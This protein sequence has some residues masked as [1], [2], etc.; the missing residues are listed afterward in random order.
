MSPYRAAR[1]SA[2]EDQDDSKTDDAISDAVD[3]I[4]VDKIEDDLI[5]HCLRKCL[6]L[7]IT[8]ADVVRLLDCKPSESQPPLW[9][10]PPIPSEPLKPSKFISA[11]EKANFRRVIQH[12]TLDAKSLRPEKDQSTSHLPGSEVAEIFGWLSIAKGVQHIIQLAKIDVEVLDWSKLDMCPE[13]IRTSCQDVRVLHL[14]WS[15]NNAVLRSWSEPEGLPRLKILEMIHLHW[16]FEMVSDTHQRVVVNIHKFIARLKALRSDVK[17]VLRP[18]ISSN[19][20][21]EIRDIDHGMGCPSVKIKFFPLLEHSSVAEIEETLVMAFEQA[22]DIVVIRRDLQTIFDKS[23]KDERNFNKVKYE[24]KD[25][26]KKDKS[27]L[28][29]CQTYDRDRLWPVEFGSIIRV[30]AVAGSRRGDFESPY[31]PDIRIPMAEYPTDSAITQHDIQFESPLQRE[32]QDKETVSPSSAACAVGLATG[33]AAL[34]M[35]CNKLTDKMSQYLT[36]STSFQVTPDYVK[37]QLERMLDTRSSKHFDFPTFLNSS[38]WV[39]A[40]DFIQNS[41]MEYKYRRSTKF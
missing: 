5:L 38:G 11:F 29:F 8:R 6:D 41:V 4:A 1:V 40:Q 25:R 26:K 21:Q 16:D 30:G 28:I 36:P 17:I 27:P 14:Y 9:F 34:I 23:W 12:V 10:E 3:K 35:Y 24:L 7:E 37:W 33:L 15:G 22:A 18:V 13:T 20:T 31:Y 32:E 39:L 19:T 2:N